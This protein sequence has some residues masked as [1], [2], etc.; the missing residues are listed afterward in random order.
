[1][2]GYLRMS[3]LIQ[4]SHFIA[5]DFKTEPIQKFL[6]PYYFYTKFNQSTY[7]NMLLNKNLVEINKA[8]I[9]GPGIKKSYI[10][11]RMDYTVIQ[12]IKG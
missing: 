7:Y 4:N 11:T 1:M 8:N 3:V 5:H 9:L 6:K 2:I 12:E 10:E